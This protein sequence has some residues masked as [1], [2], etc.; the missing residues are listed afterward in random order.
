MT[1]HIFHRWIL[2][3]QGDPASKGLTPGSF[4]ARVFT[5]KL[6][7]DIPSAGNGTDSNQN[8]EMATE[9]HGKEQNAL[10]HF[11]FFR[12]LPWIPWLFIL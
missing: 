11:R 1:G 12:V 2:R 3:M 4:T 7:V 10:E 6:P 8:L 9:P 5:Q